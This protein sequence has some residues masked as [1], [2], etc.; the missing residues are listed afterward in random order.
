MVASEV[1]VKIYRETANA[2]KKNQINLVE[3]I[4]EHVTRLKQKQ[5]V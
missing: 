4:E 1:D 2:I 5:G 3:A